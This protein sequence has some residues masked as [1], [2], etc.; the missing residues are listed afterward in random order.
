MQLQFPTLV[1]FQTGTLVFVLVLGLL[2]A[3]SDKRAE[4]I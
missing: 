1:S 3:S 4:S 2:L